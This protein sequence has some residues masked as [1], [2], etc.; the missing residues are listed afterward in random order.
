[1]Q[2]ESHVILVNKSKELIEA[3]KKRDKSIVERIICECDGDK[4]V[5]NYCDEE[6]H[7]T[8]LH[9]AVDSNNLEMVE[10]LA[11]HT[12]KLA[13]VFDVQGMNSIHIATLKNNTDIIHTLL[14]ACEYPHNAINE[15]S[16]GGTHSGY[17]PLHFAVVHHLYNSDEIEKVQSV[18]SMGKHL[19]KQCKASINATTDDNDNALHLCA[20]YNAVQLAKILIQ[21]GV[22]I[23]HQNNVGSSPLMNACV[24][25][26]I[27]FVQLLLGKD[28][29]EEIGCVTPAYLNQKDVL[30]DTALHFAVQTQLQRLFPEGIELTAKNEKIAYILARA[31]CDL[32]TLSNDSL[33]AMEFVSPT[34]QS[35]LQHVNK[36]PQYYAKDLE[37]LVLTPSDMLLSQPQHIAPSTRQ[38]FCETVQLYRKEREEADKQSQSGGCPFTKGNQSRR[39]NTSST[40]KQTCPFGKA[41]EQNSTSSKCPIPFHQQ[42]IFL[43]SYK[44]WL[45][46][47]LLIV[48][49]V[50]ARVTKQ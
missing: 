49:I 43:K 9:Y 21:Y 45:Y 48:C 13:I 25:G 20:R 34:F 41:L 35:I 2:L 3:V 17:S 4:S 7:R 18:L 46:V 36:Y 15:K 33:S 5:F 1:M 8:A 23:N 39:N 40:L 32:N 42:L 22:H 24:L 27:E 47:I 14:K 30:G 11:P 50:I 10:L 19:I 12:S 38:C 37:T 29:L 16:Q 26:N 28:E 31:G 44:F 6:Q